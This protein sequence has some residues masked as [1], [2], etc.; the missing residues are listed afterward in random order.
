MIRARR[1][2]GLRL[3][4]DIMIGE[5]IQRTQ[6][7]SVNILELWMSEWCQGKA[8]VSLGWRTRVRKNNIRIWHGAPVVHQSDEYLTRM[9]DFVSNHSQR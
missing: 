5:I 3:H 8:G 2:V 6:N 1:P 7:H 9:I 4:I